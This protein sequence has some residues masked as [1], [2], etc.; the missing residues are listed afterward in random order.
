MRA[1]SEELIIRPVFIYVCLI[2][3]CVQCAYFY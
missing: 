3:D 1:S 2:R